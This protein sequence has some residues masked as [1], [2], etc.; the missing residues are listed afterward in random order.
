MPAFSY[1]H[2]NWIF[3]LFYFCLG[4]YLIFYSKVN[5]SLISSPLLRLKAYSRSFWF[6][7]FRIAKFIFFSVHV[8]D[9]QNIK[10]DTKFVVTTVR[11]IDGDIFQLR[12][13][14]DKFLYKRYYFLFLFL[15]HIF[16][17]IF[18]ELDISELLWRKYS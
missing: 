6:F 10:D 2:T 3:H 15:L 14:I 9:Y 5:F 7:T 16:L 4:R 1:I 8:R 13:D 12:K 18:A 17:P 11:K